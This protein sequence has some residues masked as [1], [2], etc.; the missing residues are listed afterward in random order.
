MVERIEEANTTQALGMTVE[1]LNVWLKDGK[2]GA[3]GTTS[4]SPMCADDIPETTTEDVPTE[5]TTSKTGKGFVEPDFP[6]EGQ[7]STLNPDDPLYN[8]KGSW[9]Q[10][11]DDQW[12][13]KR[14]GFTPMDDKDSAWNLSK[15]ANTPVIVAVIDSGIDYSQ[16]RACR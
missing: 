15:S 10:K 9:G 13:L 12:A 4:T 1:V 11:Y 6:R 8:S 14:I 5:N 7:T 16:P 2:Q 3:A